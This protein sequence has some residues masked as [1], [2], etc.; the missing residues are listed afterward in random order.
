MARHDNNNPDPSKQINMSSRE[1]L[2]QMQL[3]SLLNVASFSWSALQ[4][5]PRHP[6]SDESPAAPEKTEGWIAAENLFI[7]TCA[8]IEQI[9][10]DRQRFDFTFQKRVEEDYAQAMRLN[11]EYIQ[12]HRDAAVQAASPHMQVNPSL[13]KMQDGSYMAVLG[14]MADLHNCIVGAGRSPQEALDAFDLAFKGI[15]KQNEQTKKVEQR[16]SSNVEEPPKRKRVYPRNRPKD[17]QDG[18]VGGTGTLPK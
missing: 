2:T 12:A 13:V 7:K 4:G 14:N 15:Q 5:P 17:G 11:L 3:T 10:E 16:A 9:V 18:E 1:L 6:F 8:A